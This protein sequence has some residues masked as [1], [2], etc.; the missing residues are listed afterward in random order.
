MRL[1]DEHMRAKGRARTATPLPDHGTVP[2]A[3]RQDQRVRVWVG[4]QAVPE[5]VR[6]ETRK[7]R[8][9]TV[10]FIPSILAVFLPN[11]SLAVVFPQRGL[12]LT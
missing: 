1:E 8:V 10:P 12:I 4:Q 6:D 9:R 5:R 3:V 7:L 11:L 2:S